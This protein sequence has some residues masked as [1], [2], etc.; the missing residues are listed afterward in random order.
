MLFA[1]NIWLLTGCNNVAG[2]CDHQ[3]SNSELFHNADLVMIKKNT[4][5]YRRVVNKEDL[6]QESMGT[7]EVIE[8]ELS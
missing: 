4:S 8:S 7:D 3:Q 6:M 2:P 5:G 1:G